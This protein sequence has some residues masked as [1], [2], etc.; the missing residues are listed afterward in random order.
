MEV[1]NV[2]WVGERS[3]ILCNQSYLAQLGDI[4]HQKRGL[5]TRDASEVTRES[6][7]MSNKW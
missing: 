4:G 7:Y 2:P 5:P 3:P 1:L 6:T